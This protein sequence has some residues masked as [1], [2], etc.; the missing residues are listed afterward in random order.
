MLKSSQNI[1]FNKYMPSILITA[2]IAIFYIVCTKYAYNFFYQDDYHLLRF[3]TVV[4][5]PN[6]S[7]QE[8]L[9]TLWGQHNEHRII[10]PRLITLIDYYFQGHID[11]AVL[12]IVSALYYLGIFFFFFKII[13]KIGLNNWYVLPV[14]LLT[15]QPASYENYYW[16]ISILQQVGNVF[17]AFFLFYSLVYFKPSKFWISLILIFILTFTHGNGL[18]AFGVGG[19]LLFLQK[20]YKDLAWW[21]VFMVAIAFVYFYGYYTAQ[22][23]NI[24]GS[25]NNPARLIGCFGGFWG[26]FFKD[27]LNGTKLA[28][29]A[30]LSV[31][32]VLLL[33]NLRT[34]IAYFSPKFE[35]NT[36]Q[37]F[38]QKSLFLLSCFLYL[39]ITASLVALSRSWSSVDAAFQNRYLHNSVIALILLYVT[40]LCY[41]S[42]I[43]QRITLFIGIVFSVVYYIFSWYSNYEFL[44]IQKQTQEAD[45][46]NYALNGVT[47][48]ND[49]PFNDNIESVLR[50]SFQDGIS[51][52][53]KT[54]LKDVVKNINKSAANN[55][56]NFP[57]E[58][59][60]D[61][62]LSL[63]ISNSHYRQ[64]FHFINLNFPTSNKIYLIL[65]SSQN[66]FIFATNHRRNRKTNFLKTGQFFTTGFFTSIYTDA[67]PS[68]NYEVGILQKNDE[69]DY[70]FYPTNAMITTK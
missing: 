24:S 11:W 57:I 8:K 23:S 27:I 28:I 20:R 61:S 48:V 66:T 33:I 64:L 38:P 58:I 15:F 65:K 50:N 10:F 55:Q 59:R 44:L 54:S 40:F 67:M 47:M 4:E 9:G 29:A 5:N 17:W 21:G 32:L 31:F 49:K 22:N 3:V 39:S 53:P 63:N 16:T 45:A 52:L 2:I 13:Q 25:L 62:V 19:I 36:E 42:K 30:G 18:F 41:Q 35:S 43:T 14:A 6:V 56:Q 46:V 70:I 34:I 37:Y 68:N 60:R 69:N 26:I 12:N 1:F 51:V 7:F